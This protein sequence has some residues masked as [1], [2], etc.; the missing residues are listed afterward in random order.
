MTISKPQ[1][2]EE[3]DNYVKSKN[4]SFLQSFLWGDFKKEYQK[5]ERIEVRDNDKILGVCQYFEE[6]SVFGSYIYI[7]HGPLADNKQVYKELFKEISQRGQGSRKI[8]ILVEPLEDIDVG[9]PAF[10]RIQPQKTIIADTTKNNEE[11]IKEFRKTTR[12]NVKNAH[13]KGVVVKKGN[14]I[15]D[16]YLLLQQTKERQDFDSYNKDYF[17]KLINLPFCELV[18][19]EY[20]KKIVA[21]T[22]L[23][24][25]GKTAYFLHSA[26][27][28]SKRNLNA[29]SLIRFKSVEFAKER[30]CTSYDFWGIDEKKYPGV[31]LFKK[32]FGGNEYIYPQGK[33]IP[34]RKIPCIL[35]QLAATFKKK[36]KK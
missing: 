5:I 16:F 11:M 2:R 1:S 24:Y 31:T 8:M 9:R 27:D 25:F 34:L 36:Y 12:H 4:G 10:L 17:E 33:I 28:S 29:T 30:G 19:A 21:A 3:W 35:F 15:N 32:G 14:S 13:K 18:L 20:Q 26:S 23:L 6:N 22:I 7:P